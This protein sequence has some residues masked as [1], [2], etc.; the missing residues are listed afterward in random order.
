MISEGT[1]ISSVAATLDFRTGL[2]NTVMG[3]ILQNID[4]DAVRR[5]IREKQTEGQQAMENLNHCKK[6]NSKAV[7]TCGQVYLGPDVLNVAVKRIAQKDDAER[8][9]N[10]KIA[11]EKQKKKVAYLKA[12]TEVA[13]LVASRWTV[14]QLKALVRYKRKKAD[15]WN[16]L[17]KMNLLM[18]NGKKSGIG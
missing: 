18:E 3:D 13:D 10:E 15:N 4:L 7:F 8:K 11:S 16:L 1:G 12:C 6:L 2:S 14:T 17:S 9:K 5:Q